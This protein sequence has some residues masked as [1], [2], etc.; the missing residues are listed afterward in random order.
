MVGKLVVRS[1]SVRQRPCSSHAVS[2]SCQVHIVSNC[3]GVLLATWHRV[4]MVQVLVVRPGWRPCRR[5][6]VIRRRLVSWIGSMRVMCGAT[7]ERT[8]TIAGRL[9]FML[10]MVWCEVVRHVVTMTL[11]LCSPFRTY[12]LWLQAATGKVRAV[13]CGEG[14]QGGKEGEAD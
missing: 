13:S 10:Q 7:I 9:R 2:R 12:V 1:M 14:L 8:N 5:S 3:L 11:S 6:S 4:G